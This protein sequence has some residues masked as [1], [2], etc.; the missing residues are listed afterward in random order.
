M[1]EWFGIAALVIALIVA[2]YTF[3]ATKTPVTPANVTTA[4]NAVPS[5]AAELE[6]VA[7]IVVQG[8]E[9]RKRKGELTN[10]QAYHDA[11]NT[12]KGW[13][14]GIAIPNDKIIRAVNSAILVASLVTNQIE[15][16]K[17]V[18]QESDAPLPGMSDPT[19]RLS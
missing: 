9:Q 12:V 3:I 15:A 13:F 4:I 7:T 2:A 14:P 8:N 6:K 10:E 19:S 17:T 11:L 5:L 1:S 18:V 16:A